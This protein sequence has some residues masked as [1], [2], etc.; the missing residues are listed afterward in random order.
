MNAYENYKKLLE[1][2]NSTQVQI[3]PVSKGHTVKTILEFVRASP[4]KKVELAENYF[5]ELQEKFSQLSQESIVWHYLGRLQSRKIPKIVQI[6]D[7]VHGVERT[8]ELEIISSELKQADKIRLKGFF[9][10]VNISGEN[11]KGGFTPEQIPSV[12]KLISELNLDSFFKGYMALATDCVQ[13]DPEKVKSEFRSLKTLRDRLSP[14]K[15]LNIGMSGD[16]KLAIAEGS[17]LVRIGTAVFGER[18]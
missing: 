8:K 3:L 9:L 17:N 13:T 16:Y 5:D 10:Q 2:I 12:L 18:T 1:E 15:W 7:Y 11:S 14:G 4:I 6:A